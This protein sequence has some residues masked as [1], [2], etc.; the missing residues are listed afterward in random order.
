LDLNWDEPAARTQGLVAVRGA[1]DALEHWLDAHPEAAAEPV[2]HASRAAALQVRAQDVAEAAMVV[3]P[4]PADPPADPPAAPGAPAPPQLRRGVS[5]D[6]RSSIEDPQMRHGRKSRSVRVDGYKRHVLQ[7][8]D[9]GVV[10][11]VGVT[12]IGRP[13]TS[14]WPTCASC[15]WTGAI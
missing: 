11:A 8:L 9:R 2:V 14:R 7:D 10:V 1:L 12:P 4:A 15:T 3:E 13:S 6:R 5:R